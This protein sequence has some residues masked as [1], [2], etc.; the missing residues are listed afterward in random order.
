MRDAFINRFLL[1]SSI[2]C[3]YSIHT[4]THTRSHTPDMPPY[5]K[6]SA[7]KHSHRDGRRGEDSVYNYCPLPPGVL[8]TIYFTERVCVCIYN[9]IK[10]CL[11]G[12]KKVETIPPVFGTFVWCLYEE[13]CSSDDVIIILYT[14]LFTRYR[15]DGHEIRGGTGDAGVNGPWWR[16]NTAPHHQNERLKYCRLKWYAFETVPC[17]PPFG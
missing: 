16:N 17:L 15:T 6:I 12:K 9:T 4:H 13:V 7:C 3:V 14:F 1:F 11:L 10:N 5:N 8:F 2:R